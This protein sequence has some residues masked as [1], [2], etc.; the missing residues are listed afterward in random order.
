MNKEGILLEFIKGLRI[1]LNTASAYSKD[2]PYFVK[3]ATEFK[4][5]IE[6]TFLSL[7]PIKINIT[8]ASLVI[9]GKVW[10]KGMLYT[11]LASF[12]HLRKV[13]SIELKPGLT[14]EEIVVFLSVISQPIKE[15][16]EQGGLDSIFH[17]ST[18]GHIIVE[19]LDYSELLRGEG[20]EVKDLWSYLFAGAVNSGN[21]SKITGF[22][23]NFDKIIRKFRPEDFLRDEELRRNLYSFVSYLKTNDAERFLKCS[24]SFLKV[25]LKDNSIAKDERLGN[26]KIFFEG[27]GKNFFS[28]TIWELIAESKEGESLN[29]STFFTLVDKITH[30]D[31]AEELHKKVHDTR[32]LLGNPHAK[33]GLNDLILAEENLMLEPIYRKSLKFLTEEEGKAGNLSFDHAQSV[34]G[35]YCVILN[36]L[37]AETDK[38]KLGLISARLSKDTN[39]MF[40]VGNLEFLSLLSRVLNKKAKEDTSINLIFKDFLKRISV[41]AENSIFDMEDPRCIEPLADSLMY[42]SLGLDFYMQKIFKEGRINQYILKLMLKLFPADFGFFLDNLEK[43]KGDIDFLS[44]FISAAASLNSAEGLEILKKIYYFSGNILKIE[45][46]KAMQGLN[47]WD[48][49]FLFSVLKSDEITLKEEALKELM[50]TES[51]KKK[52]LGILFAKPKMQSLIIAQDLNLREAKPHILSIS[53]LWFFWHWDIREKAKQILRSWN[54]KGS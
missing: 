22:A 39:V 12:F 21:V 37:S 42:S 51:T 32:L 47:F 9:D 36:L 43:T 50:K 6:S 1:A 30:Q 3:A 41:F 45:V 10:K 2:H 46:L 35:Y 7:N 25:L 31:I 48:E 54:V 8:P 14:V 16:L 18:S 33:K 38:E 4:R 49:D 5:K 23:D 40:S 17:K 13:K 20:E 27:L 19:P 34:S 52:A 15:I 24:K 28:D 44:R 53:R 26:L 29:F 11:D